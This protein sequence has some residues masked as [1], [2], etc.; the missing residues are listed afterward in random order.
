MLKKLKL[1]F[2][3]ELVLT[4]PDLDN[5]NEDGS[6]YVRLCHRRGFIYG[7]QRWIME[8]SGISLKISK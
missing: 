8:T 5:K 7:V 3:K 4:A 6:R 1:K 2:T